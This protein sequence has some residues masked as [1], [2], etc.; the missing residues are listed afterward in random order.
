MQ[1]HVGSVKVCMEKKKGQELPFE[2]TVPNYTET[3][4]KDE[5]KIYSIYIDLPFF[6]SI[7]IFPAP[8]RRCITC[9][10]NQDAK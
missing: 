8:L 3:Y 7:V 9:I 2:S 10:T 6:R 1:G 4:P 5:D